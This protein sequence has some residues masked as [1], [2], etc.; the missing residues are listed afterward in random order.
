MRFTFTHP[1]HSHPYNPELVTGSGIAAVAAAAEKAGFSGFGFTDHPAPTERWLQAGGHDAVDPFVAM[2]FAAATTTTLRLIPNIVV[3]PY[4]NPFVVAKAGA[5]LDLLSQGRFTLAVGVGYLKREFSALGV[6]FDERAALFEEALE[7]I[8]GIWTTDDFSYQGR[9]FTAEGIIAHPRPVTDPHPPIWIGGNTAAA[10]RRV[11]KFGDGW[12]PF[13]APAML[14]KTAR[15][16]EMDAD[17]LAA[18]IDDLRRRFDEAGRDFSAID[19]TFT[20]PEG[21]TPGTDGFNADA[22]LSGLEKLAA[23]GVTWMQVGLPGDSLAH[24]LDTIEEF[25]TSV[26]GK[27]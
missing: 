16:A 23:L 5:T 9:H 3:L 15:T 20:N 24:V 6:D 4:R 12:C 19:I 13:A 27:A 18:G 17:R 1:M 26:I 2:G 22:Y 7:V 11:V 25:G 10:R 8:R 14:A 21:G